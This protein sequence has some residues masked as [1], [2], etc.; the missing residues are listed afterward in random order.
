[1]D[2][3]PLQV[4]IVFLLLHTL[5]LQLLIAAGHVTGDGFTF[6]SGFSAFECDVFSGHDVNFKKACLDNVRGCRPQGDSAKN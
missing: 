1:M 6:R 2:C 4:W 5:C 3:V